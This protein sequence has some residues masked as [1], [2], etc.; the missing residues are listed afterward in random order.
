MRGDTLLSLAAQR[1]QSAF[2][3]YER[4]FFDVLMA[5]IR[6]PQVSTA[7]EAAVP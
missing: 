2:S 4:L 5:S 7:G 1:H 6:F 3:R